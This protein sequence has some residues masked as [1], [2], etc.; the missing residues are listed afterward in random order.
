[1]YAHLL[2]RDVVNN[3]ATGRRSRDFFIRHRDGNF[4]LLTV[5][6]PSLGFF[7]HAGLYA[8]LRDSWQ[9]SYQRRS[10]AGVF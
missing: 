8:R 5:A 10:Q 2:H 4:T 9:A 3:A 7:F 6:T 1:M